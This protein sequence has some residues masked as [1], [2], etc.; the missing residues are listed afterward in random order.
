MPRFSSLE[1][2]PSETRR[3]LRERLQ[4]RLG[5]EPVVQAPGRAT[6][7]LDDEAMLRLL[8][9][10]DIKTGDEWGCALET[11]QGAPA[12]DGAEPRL[13]DRLAAGWGRI[14]WGR[15]RVPSQVSMALR[16]PGSNAGAFSRV[17]ARRFVDEFRVMPDARL[18][19]YL[20]ET[21]EKIERGEIALRD[22]G[23]Q[24]PI[25]VAAR[26]WDRRSPSMDDA[27]ALRFWVDRWMVLS[28]PDLAP[29]RDWDG[30][31]SERFCRSALQ[32]L[33]GETAL[34]GWD[35]THARFVRELAVAKGRTPEDIRALIPAPPQTLVSRALWLEDNRVEGFAY[36][37]LDVCRDILGLFRLLL[38]DIEFQPFSNAPHPLAVRLLDLAS[39]R[40]DVLFSLI[41][42]AR[43][44]PRIL[45]DL[46]LHPP[47]C[48]LACL[49]ICGW[50]SGFSAF[51]RQLVEAS[52]E[53]EKVAAFGDAVSI[54]DWW[55]RKGLVGAAEAASL[56]AYVHQS[57]KDGFLDDLGE[58]EPL[59][60][61]LRNMLLALDV[62]TLQSIVDALVETPQIIRVGAEFAAALEVAAIGDIANLVRPD[63]LV[64]AYVEA[65][66]QDDFSLSVQRIGVDCSAT[67]W[68]GTRRRS[69]RPF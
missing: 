9:S 30:S 48:A 51:D 3:L 66:A 27:E 23:C 22:I 32:L 60:S 10:L 33:E 16:G 45:A 19:G 2:A 31:A 68:M 62:E 54:L 26:L 18:E 43:S 34:E 20:L 56:L 14:V 50:K 29:S 58:Q 57:A 42:A 24:S 38:D 55:L 13:E 15:V 49:I 1:Y 8:Q 47:T 46:L 59:R 35:Q 63:P 17:L 44:R 5:S 36:D 61:V 37:S 53:R 65:L 25:W 7:A 4:R 21:A 28:G 67:I 39:N 69:G 41:L 64:E 11:Y 12:S 52:G 6:L 40:A